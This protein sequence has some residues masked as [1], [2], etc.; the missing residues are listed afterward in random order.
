LAGCVSPRLVGASGV[1]P[2]TIISTIPDILRHY[3]H[4]IVHAQKEVLLATN[5][6]EKGESANIIGKALRDLSKRAVRDGRYVI[7]KLMMDHPIMANLAHFHAILPPNKWPHY[8][9]PTPDELPNVSLEVNQYHRLVMGTFHAKFLVVDRRLALLNSN[10]IQDRPNLEMMSHFEGDIVNSFYD[11]F[12]ISW[13]IRFQPNLVCLRE[14]TPIYRDFQFGFDSSTIVSVKGPLQQTIIRGRLRL[15]RHLEIEETETYLDEPLP[16][17]SDDEHSTPPQQRNVTGHD[18][19]TVVLEALVQHRTSHSPQVLVK[20]T[21]HLAGVHVAYD[22]SS[23]SQVSVTAHLNKSSISARST[24]PDKNLLPEELKKL[25]LDFT[26]FFFH[27]PHQPFPI[28]LVNRSPR[29]TPG[30][31]DIANPQNAAWMGA[32]RYAQKS[33][34]IQSPTLNASPAIDGIIAACRRGIKVTLWLDLGFNDLK[35]GLGTFQGGTN[36]HVVEKIYRK[37]RKG[38]DGAEK[39]LKTFWY[40]GKGEFLHSTD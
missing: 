22:A 27:R 11:T 7:V 18:F 19:S 5:F 38:D 39:H 28:A 15:Q 4:V 29:G 40:T 31:T 34:F 10:N 35:Q 1:I 3:Y 14:P 26:P 36:E 2:L 24:T 23:Q 32:F 37:L 17:L 30:H 9:L 12:L 6:W 20:A 13:S 21:S 25:S 16:W 8:D 33:I